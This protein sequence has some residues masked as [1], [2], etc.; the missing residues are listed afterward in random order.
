MQTLRHPPT[1][2]RNSHAPAPYPRLAEPL[3]CRRTLLLPPT[4]V[5]SAP[6][7]PPPPTPLGVLCAYDESS[8]RVASSSSCTT[9]SCPSSC[10][11]SSPRA[12]RSAA[13]ASRAARA[14][15]A[16]ESEASSLR[17]SCLCVRWCSWGCVC[18]CVCGVGFV[19]VLS[20][21]EDGHSLCFQKTKLKQSAILSWMQP[22]S[23]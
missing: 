6:P 7:P 14:S 2:N 10:S 17:S 9:A 12:A 16:A 1:P 23:Y 13:S 18:V 11:T 20:D 4:G 8:C 5:N 19:R 22:N 21:H 3:S 15:R